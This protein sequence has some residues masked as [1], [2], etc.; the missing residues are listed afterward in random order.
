MAGNDTVRLCAQC[1]K[2]VYDLSLLTRAEANELI[3]EK[4]G[5]LCIRFY[6]RADGSVL[7][8][9]C[10]NGLRALRKRYLKTRARVLATLIGVIGMMT[11]ALNSCRTSNTSQ[12][13]A[14][15]TKKPVADSM[16]AL[17]KDSIT[18][19]KYIM[20]DISTKFSDSELSQ[21]P[22]R[23]HAKKDSANAPSNSHQ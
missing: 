1:E 8:A 5:K 23:Q 17:L 19:H 15:S 22:N 4:E 20:G 10:P 21:L 14:L 12:V 3:R 2:N 7:T 16:L 11:G 6:K 9:D 13:S 18:P